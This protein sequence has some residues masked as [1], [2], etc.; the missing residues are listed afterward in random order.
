MSK[1]HKNTQ[2]RLFKVLEENDVKQYLSNALRETDIDKKIKNIER[3]GCNSV[4]GD[5]F[6]PLWEII[7]KN[8]TSYYYSE[9]KDIVYSIEKKSPWKKGKYGRRWIKHKEL[10]NKN[11]IPDSIN[12]QLIFLIPISNND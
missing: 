4:L 9:A 7:M 11:Y 5:Y 2:E 3:L 10:P 1:A 8:G 12:D 6:T